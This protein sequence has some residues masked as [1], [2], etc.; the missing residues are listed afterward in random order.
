[1]EPLLA[2][3][4][5]SLLIIQVEKTRNGKAKIETAW[6]CVWNIFLFFKI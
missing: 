2:F 5:F 3:S 4:Y 6:L 1:M